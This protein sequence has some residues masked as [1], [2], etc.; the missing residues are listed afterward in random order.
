MRADRA[1]AVDRAA[2]AIA[3]AELSADAAHMGSKAPKLV[4]CGA[5]NDRA[6]GDLA[7]A[8][9]RQHD[10][11][12]HAGRG[13]ISRLQNVP[14]ADACLGG[15]AGGGHVF[16]RAART[17][18]GPAG[19]LVA[20][21]WADVPARERLANLL[22]GNGGISFGRFFCTT[23]LRIIQAQG[24]WISHT[25]PTSLNSR[26]LSGVAARGSHA[27]RTTAGIRSVDLPANSAGENKPTGSVASRP[28][29]FSNLSKCLA[30]NQY[31]DVLRRVTFRF[32]HLRKIRCEKNLCMLNDL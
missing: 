16:H 20:A 26:P 25:G 14:R 31:K 30:I 7:F 12:S 27:S 32:S 3:E 1:A 23:H 13:G 18:L 2:A 15:L 22:G 8:D 4:R 21:V 24:E 5:A 17:G 29:L 10:G 6:R 28:P 11:I 9:Q 19:V